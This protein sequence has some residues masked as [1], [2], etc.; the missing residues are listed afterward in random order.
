MSASHNLLK[1]PYC[2][3]NA[4]PRQSPGEDLHSPEAMEPAY[5]LMDCL[6]PF[7]FCH[8]CIVSSLPVE[9]KR[10]CGRLRLESYTIVNITRN[11]RSQALPRWI[12]MIHCIRFAALS[13]RISVT[14]A[15]ILST[16][17]I[18]RRDQC[19]IR[20]YALRAWDLQ[21]E[22]QT[23]T[24]RHESAG[25]RC[26]SSRSTIH[27]ELPVPIWLSPTLEPRVYN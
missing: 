23:A 6:K 27:Y 20:S 4:Q 1:S 17:T 15:A 16:M 24:V 14:Q 8:Y 9:D 18:P 26:W 10:K 3:C 19:V 2:V 13:P 5:C 22:M 11:W 7:R 21:L 12:T 25:G